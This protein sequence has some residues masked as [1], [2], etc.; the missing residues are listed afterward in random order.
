M[1]E[2]YIGDTDVQSVFAPPNEAFQ[3]PTVTTYLIVVE[4][5][6]RTAENTLMPMFS[7]L[8]I[9]NTVTFFARVGYLRLIF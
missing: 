2:W 1:K 4:A 5:R 6:Y 9:D 8:A 7:R 3:R